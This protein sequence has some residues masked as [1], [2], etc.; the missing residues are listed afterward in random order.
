MSIKVLQLPSVRHQFIKQALNDEGVAWDQALHITTTPSLKSAIANV[1]GSHTAISILISEF[2]D[3]IVMPGMPGE[4]HVSLP[5]ISYKHMSD[6]YP[7]LSEWDSLVKG[8]RLNFNLRFNNLL[9]SLLRDDMSSDIALSIY[10][11]KQTFYRTITN[12]IANGIYPDDILSNDPMTIWAQNTWHLIEKELP[13]ICQIRE[14]IWIDP[15]EFRRQLTP[16]SSSLHKRIF[17]ALGLFFNNKAEKVIVYHGFFNY[18]ATQWALFKLID[19]LPNVTQIFIIHDD[20]I[21]PAFETWRKYFDARWRLA[22]PSQVHTIE[23][24]TP[25]SSI[26]QAA[27]KGEHIHN[28]GKLKLLECGSPTEFVTFISNEFAKATTNN[29]ITK[30][31]AADKP[32]INRYVERLGT[33]TQT[34]QIDL[35]KLPVGIFLIRLHEFLPTAFQPDI[36]FHSDGIGDIIASGYLQVKSLH[37]SHLLPIWRKV[38]PFFDG[39]TTAISWLS[40]AE[41]LYES[42]KKVNQSTHDYIHSNDIERINANADNLYKL[43]PWADITTNEANAI[44]EVILEINRLVS[45]IATKEQILL[46][47]HFA[48]IKRELERGMRNLPPQER[49]HIENKLT[50]FGIHLNEEI[51]VDELVS[52]VDMIL[53]RTISVDVFGQDEDNPS[54]IVSSLRSLDALGFNRTSSSIHLANIADG[55]FPSAISAVGWPFNISDF[56]VH[57][58]PISVQLLKTRQEYT[59]L[60]DLYL[61]WLALDGVE[62]A[63]ITISWI[64]NVAGEPY[65][66]SAILDLLALPHARVGN[67]VIDMI[68]GIEV[69]HTDRL[70]E[71]QALIQAPIPHSHDVSFALEQRVWNLINKRAR[72]SHILCHRRFAMQWGVGPTI[73]FQSTHLQEMLYGNMHG[74]SHI[75]QSQISSQ[76]VENLWPH[77]TPG[78]KVS[79]ITAG[80]VRPG[81][82]QIEWMYTLGGSNKPQNVDYHSRAYRVALGVDTQQMQT[83]TAKHYLPKGHTEPTKAHLC[84]NCPVRVRCMDALDTTLTQPD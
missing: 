43:A 18:F 19:L 48:F 3:M 50:G 80:R 60:G 69:Q 75:H 23:K 38:T 2:I 64:A 9:R 54:D 41:S 25:H 70:T 7:K 72:S 63:S 33:F 5:Q 77:L 35:A 10:D 13:E 16:H 79:R 55:V 52:V 40:R 8:K 66:R 56:E 29:N 57:A 71:G 49:T 36:C 62:D 20:G 46:E 39:C 15:N 4:S 30:L 73:A 44:Y 53:G 31:Y 45:S 47:R 28:N 74:A 76:L 81:G 65:N 83:L 78:E 59:H 17:D 84:A 67:H 24:S 82:A 42:I 51:Y 32:T 34:R 68:G 37:M 26:L 12:L 27:F 61:L 11:A 21:N 22:T 6:L 1:N 14:D 58:E